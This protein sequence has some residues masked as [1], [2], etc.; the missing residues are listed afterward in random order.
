MVAIVL[1]TLILGGCASSLG[2]SV[3]MEGDLF[4]PCPQ[5]PN[6]VSSM[7]EDDAHYVAPIDRSGLTLLESKALLLGILE[8]ERRCTIITLDQDYV[9]AEFRTLVF[10]FVDDVEFYF[11]AG[12]DVIHVRSASR[13]GESD[14][15]VNRARVTRISELFAAGVQNADN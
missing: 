13:V 9:H 1:A 10:R 14:L 8:D 7:A 11:P 15:G 3:G 5:S 2:G 4:E 12:A 6:C